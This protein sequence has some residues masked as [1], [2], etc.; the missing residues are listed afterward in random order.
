L[1]RPQG[2]ATNRTLS[3][4]LARSPDSRPLREPPLN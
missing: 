4:T 1:P 3:E 2:L